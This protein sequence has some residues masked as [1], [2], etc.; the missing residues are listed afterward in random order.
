MS[1]TEIETVLIDFVKAFNNHDA[2]GLAAFYTADARM[3]PPDAPMIV[4]RS[5]IEAM[6]QDMFDMGCQSLDLETVDVIESGDLQVEV[7]RYT[8]VIQPPGADPIQDVGKYVAVHQ[9]QSDGT[10]KLAVDTFNRDQPA[11]AG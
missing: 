6:A 2:A 1:R 11:P 10:L 4:G 7:G 5:G 9:R 8:M 3:L